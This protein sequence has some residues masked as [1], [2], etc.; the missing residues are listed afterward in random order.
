MTQAS[1][2]GYLTIK[3]AA[4]EFGLSTVWIRRMVH[5]GKLETIRVKIGETQ[6]ER[7]EI[8]RKSI[9]VRASG[10]KS[11]RD[12]GRNKYVVYATPEEY[13]HLQETLEDAG[14]G[15]LPIARANPPKSKKER[16]ADNRVA[17]AEALKESLG[18]S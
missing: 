3:E 5:Q 12:D 15:D 1:K 14:L 16:D 9:E 17:D 7:I 8:A 6:V 2:K 11:R 10:S 13:Q 4:E 18:Q